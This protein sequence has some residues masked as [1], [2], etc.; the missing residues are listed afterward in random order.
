MSWTTRHTKDPIRGDLPFDTDAP[1]TRLFTPLIFAFIQI[2]FGENSSRSL[3]TTGQS[4]I[5]SQYRIRKGIES[6]CVHIMTSPFC[7]H[8]CAS[9]PVVRTTCA[10]STTCCQGGPTIRATA[11]QLSHFVLVLPHPLLSSPTVKG[12]ALIVTDIQPSGVR[13]C[14]GLV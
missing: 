10:L 3:E 11:S 6:E 1:T 9:V 5:S 12:L 4:C 13:S 8:L 7:N 2:S 14:L